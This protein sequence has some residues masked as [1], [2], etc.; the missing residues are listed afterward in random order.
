MRF[1]QVLE[2]LPTVP[3]YDVFGTASGH[4][5]EIIPFSSCGTEKTPR[6][7]LGLHRIYQPLPFQEIFYFLGARSFLT[8]SAMFLEYAKPMDFVLANVSEPFS[9]F[10]F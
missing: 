3:R 7:F 8:G 5:E 2:N 9:W 4:K 10:L 1:C 6:E